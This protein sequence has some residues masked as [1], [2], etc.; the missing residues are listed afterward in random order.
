M[1]Q[2][3]DRVKI[4]KALADEKRLRIL[5]LLRG[6]ERCACVLEEQLDIP[7]S[8][9]SYH[10]KILCSSGRSVAGRK[11]NGPT[12]KLTRTDATGRFLS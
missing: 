3:E 2:F 11:V 6:G 9:L 5:K 1:P 10:M 8:T 12:I 7:Q 4:F